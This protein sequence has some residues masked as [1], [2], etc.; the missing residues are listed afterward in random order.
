MVDLSAMDNNWLPISELYECPKEGAYG[1]AMNALDIS[2]NLVLSRDQCYHC[3]II[4][5]AN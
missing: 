4:F 3:V 5:T 1:E 2:V